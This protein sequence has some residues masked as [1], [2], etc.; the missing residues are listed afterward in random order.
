MQAVNEFSFSGNS[1]SDAESKQGA[2]SPYVQFTL[3]HAMGGKITTLQFVVFGRQ[4]ELAETIKRGQMVTVKG[5]LSS[6]SRE[7]NGRV[8]NN[9]TFEVQDL[10][11]DTAPYLSPDSS[12]LPF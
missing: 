4:R 7:V 5:R 1:I 12:D 2:K 3:E 6:M 9:P 10:A 11:L 8:F